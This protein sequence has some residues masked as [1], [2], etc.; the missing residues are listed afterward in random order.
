MWSEELQ[1]FIWSDA[2]TVGNRVYHATCFEEAT[3]DREAGGTPAVAGG[4]S[5]TS[6][7]ERARTTTPD[8]VLGKRKLVDGEGFGDGKAVK[9]KLEGLGMV[10]G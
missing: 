7:G 6:K 10:V 1:D 2:L 5:G 8:S 4:G 3:R 9:V